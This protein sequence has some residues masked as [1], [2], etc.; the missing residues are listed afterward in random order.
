MKLAS[1]PPTLIVEKAQ[2]DLQ[3]FSSNSL[4]VTNNNESNNNNNNNNN[5]Q[6]EG[7][8][9]RAC[10]VRFNCQ[11]DTEAS[12][13]GGIFQIRLAWG[14]ESVPLI[15]FIGVGGPSPLWAMPF[16][17]QVAMELYKEVS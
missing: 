9:Y 12:L 2:Q 4:P 13:R 17:G 16:P 11:T 15:V 1:F 5:S 10:P 14:G 7:E 3:T 8:G 6:S